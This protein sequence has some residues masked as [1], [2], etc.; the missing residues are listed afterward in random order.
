[1]E[2]TNLPKG[3]KSIGVKLVYKTKFNADGK[4]DKYKARLVIKGYKQE[5]VIGYKEV[6][7]PVARLGTIELVILVVAQ[8]L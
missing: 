1:M 4:M 7:A 3:H 8:N 6:F 2:L 5:Y